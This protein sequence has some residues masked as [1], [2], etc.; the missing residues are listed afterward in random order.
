VGVPR[1]ILAETPDFDLGALRVSPARRQVCMSGECR[2]LEPKVAQVLIALA[3]ASPGVVSRDNLVEQCWGGRIVGDDALNRCILALRHLSREYS[4]EP[5]AIETVP[6]VGYSLL[7][8]PRV[9]GAAGNVKRQWRLLAIVLLPVLMIT[10]ALAVYWYRFEGTGPAPASIAV[11][12]FRNLTGGNA[13]FSD[14]LSEEILDQLTREPAFRVAGPVSTAATA[15]ESDL[16]KVGGQLGVDY[17][18]AGSVRSG[19][20]RVRVTAALVRTTDGTRLW[21]QTYDR[22]FN[23]VLGIEIAIGQAVASGL[24]RQLIH[25]SPAS[26]AVNGQAYALYLN[27]RGLLRSGNPET[28]QGAIHILRQAIRID[29]HFAPAWAALSEAVILNS[30]TMDKEGVIAVIPEARQAATRAL[31]IDPNLAAGHETLASL[32][33]SDTPDAVAHEW[34]A[35]QLDPR[36]AEGLISLSVAEHVS[37]QFVQSLASAKRARSADPLAQGP[38]RAILN[39]TAELG[40]HAGEVA[41]INE[42]FADD[43]R[44]RS[45][46]LARASYYAGDFS[47]AAARWAD[48]ANGTSQWASPSKLSLQN[49]LLMLNLSTEQPSRPPRP[50]IGP[51]RSLPA[52]VWMT[53]APSA[54]EWQRRNRSWAAELVY[55][56]EDVIAAKRML[57]EGRAKELVATYDGPT[58]LLGLHNGMTVGTC[59]LENAAIA[60]MALRTVGRSA[61]A[62]I[63]LNQAD[64]AIVAAYRQGPV[65]MWLDQD[66]A[67]VWALQGKTAQA[68]TALDRA[69]RRG[70]THTSRSDLP[71]L[72]DEPTFAPLHSNRAFAVVAAKYAAALTR[73]RQETARVLHIHL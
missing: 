47:D 68:V 44:I 64:H 37:G 53:S 23:D 27:A 60:A 1:I 39:Q 61:E 13:Y 50:F 56:D 3:A 69:F 62:S 67:G 36:S 63:L 40:D 21:S 16:R 70:S 55:R 24:E 49:V 25:A 2:E 15:S 43:P 71:R 45:F 54:T 12:P 8:G 14:G 58:G 59:Y 7:A 10:A 31:A 38:P 32:L 18:L 26:H 51:T 41:L 11:L 22:K 20:D 6:R 46:A 30:E 48:L 34:R 42:A 73:E 29:P 72:E 35:A 65:P 28:G 19:G 66:A 52:R 57:S 5:F 33:G 17:V 9:H 4:P